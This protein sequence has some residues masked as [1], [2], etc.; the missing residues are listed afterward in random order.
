MLDEAYVQRILMNLL[1]NALKFTS[2]GFVM[3]SLDMDDGDLV[4][5]V[6][7]SGAGIPSSFMPKLWEPFSQAKTRGTQRGT[8]LGLTIVK[9]LLHKMHGDIS[10]ESRHV[11]DGFNPGDTGTLFTIRIPVQLSPG[12][13]PP[14]RHNMESGTV[15][16]FSHNPRL[17]EGLKQAR[18][19]FGYEVAVIHHFSELAS[20][21]VK[22]AWAAY[23][24]LAE[25]ADCLRHL[26]NQGHVTTFVP[27]GHQESLQ[28][29]PGMLSAP[30]L[31]PL[32]KPLVWHTFHKRI[33]I[34][35]HAAAA[36]KA[37][38]PVVENGPKPEERD[39]P[40]GKRQLTSGATEESVTSATVNVLLVEDNPVGVALAVF[41]SSHFSPIILV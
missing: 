27:H 10:V 38:P 25:H 4:A 18:Q 13:P 11:D 15:A 37:P 32:P 3:L 9:Q 5:K 22:Y 21:N 20:H 17:L 36:L 28:Q 12:A 30:H 40:A 34:A 26:L 2:S 7:D 29:L 41:F 39:R 8:G 6:R 14:A 33:A 24:Y 23:R 35:S 16:L 19:L 1:S 31:V